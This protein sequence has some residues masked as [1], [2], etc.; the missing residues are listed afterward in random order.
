MKIL[1]KNGRVFD[2]VQNIDGNYDIFIRNGKIDKLQKNINIASIEATNIQVIDAKKKFVFPGLIDMHT[3]L[4]EPG[5]EGKE[6]I[7]SGT[8]AAAKGGFTTICCMPNTNPCLDNLPAVEYIILKSEKEAIVNVLPV[9]CITKNQQGKELSEIGKLIEA[10][11]VAISDDGKPVMDSFIMSKALEYCKIFDIPIISHC[12][13]LN[14]SS[15]GV[16]N[17]GEISTKLGLKG[18]PNAAEEVM[19]ARDIILSDLTGGHVHI[20]HI[21]T[22]GSVDLI[23]SAKKKGINITCETA[24]HYFSLTEKEVLGYNTN[25]KMNPPLRTK[26]DVAAIKKGLF[27][28]TIDCIASDHAPH[29]KEEKNREFDLAPFGIIGLE[30]E[31]SL[32]YQELVVKE[33]MDLLEMLKKFTLNP[34]KIMKIK[35][36]GSLEIGNFA[37]IVIFNPNEKF[38]VSDKIISKSSNTPF[39][40]WE[41]Q[42]VVEITIVN[43]KI[44]WEKNKSIK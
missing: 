24:P 3:H 36:R 11:V 15:T 1:I 23:R 22:K 25:A 27:D 16:I 21:S 35:K 31:L 28:G 2:P 13:D 14:L 7:E 38:K 12:E 19:V 9:G 5:A 30:T 8:K 43:G 29:T 40:D 10:G 37:D 33:K 32:S 6:T 39:L 26:K 44:V 34:Q 42:G 41:L 17:E 18:I 4:R 20:A